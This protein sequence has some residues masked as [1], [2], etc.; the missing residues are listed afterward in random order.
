MEATAEPRVSLRQ[1]RSPSGADDPAAGLRELLEQERR[2]REAAERT[3]ALKDE[4]LAL[5]SH[6]LRSPLGAILGWTH[7]LRR[8]GS[9]A[10][11]AKGLEVIE[12]SALAQ[13]RLIDDLLD[14]SRITAGRL[15]LDNQI[16]EPRTLIDAAVEALRPAAEAKGIC[17]AK[18]LRLDTSP[19]RGDASR[20]QQVIVNLLSNAV[21]FTPAQGRIEVTLQGA[22]DHV[23]IAVAD[24]GVGIAPQ[25]LP[26]VFERYR[27]LD[28]PTRRDE[29]LGLGLAIALH[30]VE[31]HGGAIEAQSA[32]EGR[33]A[34][35]AVR[36][37]VH[38]EGVSGS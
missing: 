23:E 2:A 5:V 12:Q 4:F 36:L 14:I 7:I 13:N 27:R 11:L 3:S 20:L 33:G 18:V 24:N 35:F 34:R 16:V 37:P 10:D 31:L 1:E 17:V 26:H 29:G 30:L 9:A 38:R 15:R 8:G 25:F 28:G 6:E 22:P 19:V 32:G 21:K